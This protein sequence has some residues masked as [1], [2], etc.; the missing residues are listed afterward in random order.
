M[1]DAHESPEWLVL[2]NGAV[3]MG[4]AHHIHSAGGRIRMLDRSG[5]CDQRTLVYHPLGE[6]MSPVRWDCSFGLPS[7]P[8]KD[9]RVLVATKAFSVAAALG[10]LVEHLAPGSRV[11]FLQNGLGFLPEHLL[12]DRVEAL[13]V[14]NP[15]FSVNR[16]DHHTVEQ[17][18][19]A[20]MLV[21]DAEGRVRPTVEVGSDL[22]WLQSAG[23][24]LSWSPSIQFQRWKKL[25]I[26]AV[27]NPLTV[28]HELSNGELAVHPEARVMIDRMSAECARIMDSTGHSITP[29]EL[30]SSILDV[31]EM[32]APNRNSML[33]DYHANRSGNELHHIMVPLID[34]ARKHELSCPDLQAV[35]RR[36]FEMFRRAS[37]DDSGPSRS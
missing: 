37:S 23:I 29:E 6:S 15:G 18:G 19:Y 25:A 16:V 21:G 27:I 33:Q 7:Q 20:P 26:N 9:H 31:L 10:P 1:T 36:V 11:Y 35:H 14:V 17:T 3:G 24:D 28:I 32:T 5:T 13:F 30:R 4:L 12:P 22:E 8:P 2:G 34:Q